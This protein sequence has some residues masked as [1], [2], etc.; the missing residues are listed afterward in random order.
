MWYLVVYG[1]SREASIIKSLLA[2]WL[3]HRDGNKFYSDIKLPLSFPPQHFMLS[4]KGRSSFLL[5][6]E[7]LLVQLA[8]F[9]NHWNFGIELNNNVSRTWGLKLK[10]KQTEFECCVFWLLQM[11]SRP[12]RTKGFPDLPFT[13]C[14]VVIPFFFNLWEH[15][16]YSIEF[17]K[18]FYWPFARKQ[19]KIVATGY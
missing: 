7:R 12:K 2:S 6:S 13:T 4:G 17:F 5:V 19:N 8:D 10:G 9:H 1:V 18:D 11:T 14:T 16:S 15:N 3:T